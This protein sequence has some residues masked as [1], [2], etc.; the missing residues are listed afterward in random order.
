MN[1]YV[2][3]CCAGRLIE[4]DW[5]LLMCYADP[6]LGDIWTDRQDKGPLSGVL[7]VSAR[8]WYRCCSGVNPSKAKRLKTF[9]FNGVS[10]TCLFPGC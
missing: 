1:A 9:A 5:L 8:R 4:N 6:E 7:P 3:V 2:R 10:D